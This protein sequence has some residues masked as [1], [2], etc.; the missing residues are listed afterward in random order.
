[1]TKCLTQSMSFQWALVQ[2]VEVI[3][4][5]LMRSLEVVIV[6]YL[7]T[8]TFLGVRLQQKPYCMEFF[9][10]KIKFEE[11]TLLLEPKL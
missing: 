2:M 1:M 9:N 7:L 11:P 8:F 5:I 6:L 10:Y 3:I 4:I